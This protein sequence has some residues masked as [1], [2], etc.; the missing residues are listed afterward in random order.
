M[1]MSRHAHRGFT[2][3]EILVVVVILG[4]LATMV[5]PQFLEASIRAKS[6]SMLAQVQTVRKALEVYR[7]EHGNEYPT[8]AQMWTNLTIQTDAAGDAGGT[9]GPYLL[10]VPNNPFSNGS[11]IAADNSADWQYDETTGQIRAVVA[12]STIAKLNLSSVDVVPQ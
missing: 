10:K 7:T 5:V 11:A 4:I 1:L 8:L 9:L 3:V 2:L 12:P 6:S